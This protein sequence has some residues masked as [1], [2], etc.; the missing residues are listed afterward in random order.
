MSA[1]VLCMR[2]VNSKHEYLE[3]YRDR[4]R[5]YADDVRY[6]PFRCA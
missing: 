3:H 5:V 2:E 6:K 1:R 4:E